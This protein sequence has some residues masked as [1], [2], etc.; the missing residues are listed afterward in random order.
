MFFAKIARLFWY[1]HPAFGVVGHS[2]GIVAWILKKLVKTRAYR[3]YE[4]Q[5]KPLKINELQISTQQC[6]LAMTDIVRCYLVSPTG[7]F[8]SGLCCANSY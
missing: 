6:P 8:A 1:F 2:Q 3:F 7:R 5:E 4:K